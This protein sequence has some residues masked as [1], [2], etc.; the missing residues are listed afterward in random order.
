MVNHFYNLVTDFY[1]HGWGQCFHF[2][3]RFKDEDFT[4][5]IRRTEFYLALRTNMTSKTKALDVGCGIGGPM[6]NIAGFSGSTIEGITINQYQVTVGNKYNEKMG[7]ADRCHLTQG[8]FQNLPWKENTYD[9]AYAIEA[10]CHSPD[11][12]R[13]FKEVFRVLK[14]GGF[15]TGYEWTMTDRFDSSNKI[16]VST[17]EGIE[18]GNGLPTLVHY[19]VILKNLKDAGFE[20]IDSFDANRGAHDSNQI[21]WY[22]TLKGEMSLS[23]FRMSHFGRICTHILVWTLET[24]RIAPHGSTKVSALLNATAI[25]I[26]EGGKAGIFTPSYFFLVRKPL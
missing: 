20:V 8:D 12:V 21:P 1:V 6:R 13:T 16:Q 5:S 26:V 15:F 22:D 4:Q 11:R 25:D 9:V 14:P 24:L 18:V 23:G 10:T 17:K 2:G 19:S 3:P 7:L